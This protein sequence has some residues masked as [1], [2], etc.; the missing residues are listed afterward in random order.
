MLGYIE[1]YALMAF[2]M[3]FV[4]KL[5]AEVVNQV[6]SMVSGPTEIQKDRSLDKQRLQSWMLSW[7]TNL[8]GDEEM[9]C[10]PTIEY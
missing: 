9:G 8:V 6:Q 10:M 1:M 3:A 4:Y 2:Q 5:L 7:M